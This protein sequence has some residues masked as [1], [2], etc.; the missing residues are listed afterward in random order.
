V[1]VLGDPWAVLVLRDVVF[2]GH[3]HA[4]DPMPHFEGE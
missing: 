4:N 2:G 1:E 3:C